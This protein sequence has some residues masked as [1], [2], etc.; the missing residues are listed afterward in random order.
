MNNS[1]V[2]DFSDLQFLEEIQKP[3]RKLPKFFADCKL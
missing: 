2:S 1:G 3:I